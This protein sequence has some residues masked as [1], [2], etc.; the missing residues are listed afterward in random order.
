MKRALS[1]IRRRGVDQAYARRR[2]LARALRRRHYV[3]KRRVPVWIDVGV[4]LDDEEAYAGRRIEVGGGPYPRRGFVHVD[5]DPHAAHL[6]AVTDAWD[7]PFR[8]AWAQELIAVHVLEHVEPVRLGPTLSEWHRVLEPGG[9]LLIHVP[10]GPALMRSFIDAPVEEKWRA[11]GSLL[12]QY[13]GP[14]A[15]R[16]EEIWRR[17]DHQ[18]IF[19][20]DLLTW[21]LH[22]ASFVDVRDVSNRV[23]DRH[24]EA[25]EEFIPA[26]S[27]V[28][29]ARKDSR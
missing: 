14:S 10:N 12:G 1:E 29:E 11:M 19:D 15:K 2:A 27:L 23:R 28:M 21:A 18:I 7:L 13:C 25:W 6:E 3:H 9:S 5:N 22:R 17:A 4:G 16:P 24:S 26:Y 8:D 20:T